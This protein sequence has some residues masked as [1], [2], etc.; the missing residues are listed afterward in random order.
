M[1]VSQKYFPKK[2]QQYFQKYKTREATMRVSKR[3]D[4]SIFPKKIQRYKT[5]DKCE[6]GQQFSFS[7]QRGRPNNL[8]SK[9]RA[10]RTTS[11]K[12]DPR[13]WGTLPA[14]VEITNHAFPLEI[15]YFWQFRK[16]QGAPSVTTE[17][18]CTGLC[19]LRKQG[20]APPDPA[21]DKVGLP[22]S[23]NK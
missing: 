2:F 20:K 10:I 23:L 12:S 22:V 21:L 9:C 1:K 4:S 5:R 6:G 18:P 15:L 11:F 7:I 3:K 13:V 16:M 14:E 19:M 8:Q 17:K